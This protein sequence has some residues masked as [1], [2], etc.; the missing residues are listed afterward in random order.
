MDKFGNVQVAQI[1]IVIPLDASKFSGEHIFD[2]FVSYRFL[3]FE[4]FIV[5]YFYYIFFTPFCYIFTIYTYG[6]DHFTPVKKLISLNF[7]FKPKIRTPG[8]SIWQ[9]SKY[10]RAEMDIDTSLCEKNIEF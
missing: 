3:V 5:L 7:N 4:I 8:L 9:G 6:G 10:D 2:I 1:C